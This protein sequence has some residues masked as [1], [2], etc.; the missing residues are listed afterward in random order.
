MRYQEILYEIDQSVLTI[1]LNRPDKLNAFTHQMRD[2]LI[3]AFDRADEDDAVRA[4]I[5]TGSGLAF[6]A[7]ENL[8]FQPVGFGHQVLSEKCGSAAFVLMQRRVTGRGGSH[9]QPH[10]AAADQSGQFQKRCRDG[11]A[12]AWVQ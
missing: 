6:C 1:T 11:R 2:E 5:V 10:P 9:S 3:D 8:L 7:G 12:V 4:I